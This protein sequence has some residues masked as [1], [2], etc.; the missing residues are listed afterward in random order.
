MK[1]GTG[2]DFFLQISAFR[3]C[4]KLRYRPRSVLLTLDQFRRVYVGKWLESVA[5]VLSYTGFSL[6]R[7]FA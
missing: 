4:G 3:Q 2:N 5:T 1:T 6:L 7:V